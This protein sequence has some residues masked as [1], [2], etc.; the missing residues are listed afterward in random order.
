MDHLPLQAAPV[1]KSPTIPFLSNE[2][3]SW[4]NCMTGPSRKCWYVPES[5]SPYLPERL[6]IEA[7]SDHEVG[8]LS[9]IW[10]YSGLLFKNTN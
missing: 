3:Y 1:S 4:A 6:S 2:P 8:A 5:Y 9:Q 7:Q 10:L